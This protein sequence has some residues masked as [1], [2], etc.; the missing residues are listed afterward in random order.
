MFEKAPL[1]IMLLTFEDFQLEIFQII[2]TGTF[3]V[4]ILER[5]VRALKQ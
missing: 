3:Y 4:N 2:S 5:E 1:R